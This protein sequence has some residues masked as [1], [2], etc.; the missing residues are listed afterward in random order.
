MNNMII[1]KT[2]NL[3]NGKIYVGKD[4]H[5]KSSY[6]GSGLILQK[7][8]KK[9]GKE[10]FKKEILEICY[11][12]EELSNRE[13]YWIRKLDSCNKEIGYNISL[14][15]KGGD[16]FTQ[17][18]NKEEIRA[19][20]SRSNTGRKMSEDWKKKNSERQIGRKISK[21]TIEKRRI[22]LKGRIITSDHRKKLSEAN[23]GKKMSEEIKQKISKSLSGRRLSPEHIEKLTHI[24]IGH[25]LSDE[26]KNKISASETG[27]KMS[28]ESREKMSISQN[29]RYSELR[30]IQ[31]SKMKKIAN[32]RDGVCL[33]NEYINR[34]TK[35]L[36][37]CKNHHQWESTPVNITMGSWCPIC[38]K[39]KE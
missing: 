20:I 39:N 36:W 15:G 14:G 17:N 26:T 8:V 5:N 12:I 19:K 11:S 33:S 16:N 21:E 25:H 27:K 9:Y 23:K 30:S 31:L 32:N 28:I 22:K 13:I 24:R 38:K 1:Y 10:N 37:E 29:N 35:L 34:T 4:T 2:T 3:I 18:P 6:L 7:A